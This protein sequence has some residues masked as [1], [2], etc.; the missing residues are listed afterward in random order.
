MTPAER[1][2]LRAA[3]RQAAAVSPTMRAAILRAFRL[4]REALSDAEM[5]RLIAS[6][7]IEALAL[8]VVDAMQSAT[9]T[10]PIRETIRTAYRRTAIA[11]IRTLPLPRSLVVEVAFDFLNPRVV[12]AITDLESRALATLTEETAQVVRQVVRRGITDGVGPRALVP[13][14]RSRIGLAPSQ[15]EQVA[16]YRRALVEGDFAHARRFTARD[17]RFDAAMR[18]GAP[19]S[20]EQVDRMTDAYRRVRQGQNAATHARTAMLDATRAGQRASWEA[21]IAQGGLD[22]SRMT[23]RWATTKDG[24]QRPEHDRMHGVTVGFDDLFPVDGGVLVPGQNTY[25]CRCVAIYRYRPG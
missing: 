4:V 14:L 18:R 3:E 11:G 24:R 22:R 10:A 25:N 19:L 15:E 12:E 6:G 5:A 9:T 7:N 1:A 8:A 2:V 17:K 16:S 23:K 20:P 13:I 21:A